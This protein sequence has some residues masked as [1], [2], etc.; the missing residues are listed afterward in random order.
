LTDQVKFGLHIW[1]ARRIGVAA[2]SLF[3]AAVFLVPALASSDVTFLPHR[4]VYDLSLKEASERS[5]IN[6]MTGR[7]V[8]EL[9]GSACEGY[10]ARYRYST[11]IYMNGKVLDNDQHSTV[12]ESADGKRFDFITQYYL[13]GQREQNLRGKAMRNDKGIRV[14]L[15]K[16]DARNVEL[17][18]ALFMNQHLIKIV[19]AARAGQTF[20]TKRVFDGSDNGDQLVDTNAV[21]GKAKHN[22]GIRAGEPSDIK[23]KFADRLAWPVSVSYFKTGKVVGGGERLPSYQVSFLLYEDGVSRDLT[24]RYDDY[25]LNAVLTKIEYLK[26]EPCN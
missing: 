19:K 18:Q 5:G 21:I 4:A 20:L 1:G 24:M 26:S 7:I 6:A 14:E 11:R 2:F 12:F 17:G 13:N 9:T 23:Q 25:S 16:P 8:Y 22:V 10:A 15:S 3:A